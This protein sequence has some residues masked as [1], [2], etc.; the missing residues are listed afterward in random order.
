VRTENLRINQLPPEA[1]ARYLAYLEALD[2]KD[3]ARYGAFLAEGC[4]MQ[5]GHRAL[6]E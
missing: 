4:V 6:H 2:A 5:I 3:P 1:S